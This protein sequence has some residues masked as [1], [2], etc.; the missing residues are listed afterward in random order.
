M[1]ESDTIQVSGR[2]TSVDFA[3]DDTVP[4]EIAERS[5][6]EYLQVC[7]GLYSRGTVS[8]NVGRRILV[9]E[10]LAAIK[11]ILDR[12]TGLTV[13]RYWCAPEILER[14]PW[15]FQNPS[16]SLG[17]LSSF[18]H[19]PAQSPAEAGSSPQEGPEDSGVNPGFPLPADSGQDSGNSEGR[20]LPLAMFLVESFV[21][22]PGPRLPMAITQSPATGIDRVAR[23][24]GLDFQGEKESDVPGGTGI[25]ARVQPLKPERFAD[26]EAEAVPSEDLATIPVIS[27]EKDLGPSTVVAGEVTE[28]ITE[29]LI[30]TGESD[31]HEETEGGFIGPHL[32]RGNEAL[33][34]KA[35]CRSGEIIQYPGDVVVFGDVNPG[36]EIIAGGDVVVLGS[37][38][39]MVQAGFRGDA[40]A[41][42]FALNL[43]A[44]RLQ[45]GASTGEAPARSRKSKSG[46]RSAFP[47]IAYLCRGSIFVAPFVRRQ[48]EYQGGVLYE[49]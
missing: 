31:S 22:S 21:G 39:G 18:P 38:R 27:M 29:A 43:E 45:I 5:L 14:A 41:T 15:N 1:Q 3:I 47:Q 2:G 35:T 16:L 24:D 28:P 46:S 10:Q 26:D 23:G 40:G 25:E 6:L 36:A 32:R 12:E 48:E 8:V 11:D 42:I 37:L 17:C 44:Q 13:T 7:R 49:G 30:S 33:F 9:P 20:Q 34:I 19:G 4:F